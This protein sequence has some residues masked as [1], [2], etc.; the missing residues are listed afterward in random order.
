MFIIGK[1]FVT[2]IEDQLDWHG[3]PLGSKA[4]ESLALVKSRIKNHGPHG[5]K[6]K[7][8]PRDAP[9]VDLNVKLSS[10]P[11]YKLGEK[12]LPCPLAIIVVVIVVIIVIV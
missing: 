8:F 4:D 10:P 11:N 5:I 9:K 6:P 3:K 1:G 12:V 7:E 2:E